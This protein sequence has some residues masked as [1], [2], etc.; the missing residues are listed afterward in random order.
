MTTDTVH[1]RHL[2]S[3]SVALAAAFAIFGALPGGGLAN[4]S[5]QRQSFLVVD[6]SGA[7]SA[8]NSSLCA[9][10]KTCASALSDE[11]VGP[12]ASWANAKTQYGATGNGVTD[13]TAALQH[14]LDDLGTP[15]HS[16]VG[17]LPAGTYRITG[18][19]V[20]A[21]RINVSL[22]GEDPTTTSIRW[23]GP[24]G[25]TMLSINGFAYSRFD[26][27]TFDG[28]RTAGVAVDQSWSGVGNYFDTG[29]EYADDVFQDAGTG[30]RGGARGYGFAETSILRCHFL[31][32]TT[33]GLSLG[34]FNAL[35]IWVWDSLFD[36]NRVGITNQPGAGNY[37][38]YDSNFLNSTVSDLVIG[39][40]GT[41]NIRGNTSKGSARFLSAGFTVNPA[42][43]TLQG[44]MIIDPTSARAISVG[45]LGPVLLLDNKVQSL[46]GT[47]GPVV[48]IASF[49][50]EDA[51]AFN[52]TFTVAKPI[53]VKGRL[54]E[55]GT[56][57]ASSLSL[58]VPPLPGV[59]PNRHRTVFDVPGGSSGTVVQRAINAAVA[60]GDGAVVH[61]AAGDDPISQPLVIPSQSQIQLVG[62]GGMSRLV[63]A[64]G[65]TGPVLSLLG[66][67]KATL[68]DFQIEGTS[69]VEGIRVTNADQ[70]G[71]RIAIL[72]AYLT[73]NSN[74][75]VDR[76][77][78]TLV[79][80]EDFEHS[81]ATGTSVQIDG[82]PDAAGG[83][84][85]GGQ[86]NLLSGASSDNALSYDV[87]DGA[88]AVIRDI[89]Y[90][91]SSSAS[92]QFLHLSGPS[93]VTFAGSRV[94]SPM[95]RTFP[96]IDIA[97]QSQIAL[98]TDDIDD[99]VVISGSGSA[100]DVLG[101]GLLGHS[102]AGYF[103][104]SST[105]AAHAMLLNSAQT[106][107]CCNTGSVQVPEQGT[108]DPRFV[109]AMLAQAR[110]AAPVVLSP[111]PSGVTDVRMFR[112]S[113]NRASVAIHLM[114]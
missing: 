60:V 85:D 45:N 58:S 92:P 100:T 41:F 36:S 53:S 95:K 9:T 68:R 19:L 51:F 111:T 54:H 12:F 8:T 91:T 38:V 108:Y 86:T 75:W 93:T 65:A 98:L 6:N 69:S 39:N 64:G 110:A 34:N 56:V 70:P 35:D 62:D 28:H 78:R 103:Q 17:W 96:A 42:L 1:T 18:T 97:G 107:T 87:T 99:R 101:L 57:V 3:L 13:D 61:L 88:H 113:V 50:P 84:W 11:F 16:D 43:I 77:D 73:S 104:N 15:G 20:M 4:A 74:L 37:D 102:S 79:Q 29:N 7:N 114:P 94:S 32:N 106:S 33:A 47:V 44:N 21:A 2:L 66:P 63:W 24:V 10:S 76:L 80:L 55:I 5:T 26:R 109:T 82:G 22:I 72:E 71:A 59:L 81:Q 105:P 23:D 112:V 89:W 27:I 52:N 90:E 49:K 48:V 83:H 40:T 14:L 25:G 67:S 30:L 46:P 31:R